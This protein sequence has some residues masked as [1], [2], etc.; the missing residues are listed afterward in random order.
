MDSEG[1][2]VSGPDNW[3]ICGA[4]CPLKDD[5][6]REDNTLTI[7]QYNDE[8]EKIKILK[9]FGIK[10]FSLLLIGLVVTGL[11]IYRSER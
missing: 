2:H 3:R 10:F 7:R 9:L 1:N 8:K 11:G 4:K 6:W 5:A